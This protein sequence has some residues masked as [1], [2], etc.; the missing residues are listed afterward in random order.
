M[1]IYSSLHILGVIIFKASWKHQI[2]YL[3]GELSCRLLLRRGLLTVGSLS[4][5]LIP[6]VFSCWGRVNQVRSELK[7]LEILQLP[8]VGVSEP[9]DLLIG[10]E[11]VNRFGSSVFIRARKLHLILFKR[12]L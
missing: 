4:Q 5:L 11:K 6:L 8:V 3:R 10:Y 12:G 2:Q 9:T 1:K 7:Q